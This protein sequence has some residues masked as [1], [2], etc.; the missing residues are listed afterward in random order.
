MT[1][2]ERQRERGGGVEKEGRRSEAVSNEARLYRHIQPHTHTH[3]HTQIH[4]VRHKEGFS[5]TDV[6]TDNSNNT[7]CI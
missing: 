7:A 1:R 6:D 2:T 4:A 3:T 5:I